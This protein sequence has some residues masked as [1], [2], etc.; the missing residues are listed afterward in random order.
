[1]SM[2]LLGILAACAGATPRP[3]GENGLQGRWQGVVQRDGIGQAV[4][5]DLSE[6]GNA[7][8]G[9]LS[10]PDKYAVTLTD[11]T[12]HGNRVHFEAPDGTYDGEVSGDSIAGNVSG[13]STGEFSLNKTDRDWTPYPFGP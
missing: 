3:S 4:E 6:S 2:G 13:A 7:W 8:D 11:V 1:M 12:V 10:G 5:V 9:V